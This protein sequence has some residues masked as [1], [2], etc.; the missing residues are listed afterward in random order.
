MSKTVQKRKARPVKAE[1][2]KRYNVWICDV[3]IELTPREIDKAKGNG[4]WGDLK[5]ITKDCAC[6]GKESMCNAYDEGIL[7]ELQENYFKY[8]KSIPAEPDFI[9]QPES[10]SN[11]TEI[12]RERIDV[13]GIVDTGKTNIIDDGCVM[14]TLKVFDV[15]LIPS[16]KVIRMPAIDKNEVI[17]KMRKWL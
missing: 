6:C 16:G 4:A 8:E 11:P 10:R 15:P 7:S 13:D 1:S 17:A 12:V 14:V 3:C 5:P 9:K 2:K